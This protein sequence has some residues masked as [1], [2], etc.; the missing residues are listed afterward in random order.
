MP[1]ELSGVSKNITSPGDDLIIY[2]KNDKVN[3]R[4]NHKH[5]NIND[6]QLL[7]FRHVIFQPHIATAN[8]FDQ[9]FLGNF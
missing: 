8:M 7:F 6:L 4:M 5:L 9:P 2:Q 1:A 3:F